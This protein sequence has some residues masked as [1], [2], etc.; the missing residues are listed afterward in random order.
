MLL[1]TLLVSLQ[2]AF[3]SIAV[4]AV[5]LVSNFL[6]KLHLPVFIR[7]IATILAVAPFLYG[8]AL[9]ALFVLGIALPRCPLCG[10]PGAPIGGPT[11]RSVLSCPS[12]GTIRRRGFFWWM[13]FEAREPD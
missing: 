11:D 13:T 10:Q 12:C 3:L 8:A 5:V 7:N 9:G 6:F 4:G 2:I 1:R